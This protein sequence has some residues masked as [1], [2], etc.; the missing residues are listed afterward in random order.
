VNGTSD[1]K[2]IALERYEEVL[3]S[4]TA[5]DVLSGKS[6]TLGEKLTLPGRG[7]LLLEF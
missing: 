1:D 3:P 7:F 5:K 6:V 4:R 2:E